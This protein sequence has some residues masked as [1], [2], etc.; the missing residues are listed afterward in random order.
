MRWVCAGHILGSS[1]I[2]ESHHPKTGLLVPPRG[3]DSH[4]RTKQRAYSR[5]MLFWNT[6]NMG[7][8]RRRY[9]P[10]IQDKSFRDMRQVCAGTCWPSGFEMSLPQC[11]GY[12]P[13]MRWAHLGH[14]PHFGL[15]SLW[16]RY[17]PA[18]LSGQ[19]EGCLGYA[20]NMSQAHLGHEPDSG[21]MSLQKG[22]LFLLGYVYC[23]R[24]ARILSPLRKMFISSIK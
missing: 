16:E 3:V 14:Q 2:R 23:P 8:L 6:S 21:L 1:H 4:T 18:S 13:G 20:P 12:A 17:I 10:G 9:A 15:I 11:L 24:W 22:F 19:S 5:Q 7:V